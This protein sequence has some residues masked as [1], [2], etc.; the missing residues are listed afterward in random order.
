MELLANGDVFSQ[1]RVL[2]NELTI[3]KFLYCPADKKKTEAK[4][5]ASGMSDNNV[6]YFLNLDA[7]EKNPTSLLA[8][9]RNL[10]N[11]APV[12]RRLIPITKDATVG[13]T[14][15]IHFEQGNLLFGDGHVGSFT[16]TNG[17]A[18]AI[19]K[20]PDGITNRLAIP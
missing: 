11:S 6:S 12:G 5:F 2:S 8:G 9:D 14:K 13:W 7:V 1:F 17:D 16:F 15:E 10:T 4:S 18:R 20:I 19:I 3:P